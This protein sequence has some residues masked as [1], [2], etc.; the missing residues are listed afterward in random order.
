M[1]DSLSPYV[2]TPLSHGEIRLLY[3]TTDAPAD[4]TT[5]T[6]RAKRLLRADGE[7]PLMYDA[8]S[9]TWGSLGRTFPFVCNGKELQIH[10]NLKE[11]LPYLARRKSS[12]PIWIDAVC[13]N[14]T[15]DDE[16][17]VQI[18][19]M[20]KIYRQAAMAWIW[21][22]PLQ[23]GPEVITLFQELIAIGPE[24]AELRKV[25]K[26]R[27]PTDFGL[28]A[29][30]SPIWRAANDVLGN[31]WFTRVWIVQEAALPRAVK[32]LCG[33]TE[34][35]WEIIE[36]VL[37]HLV[38][39]RYALKG[40]GNARI[41]LNWTSQHTVFL[42]RH[43]EKTS[44][45]T[46]A[47]AD[48]ILSVLGLMAGNHACYDPRDY[49]LALMGFVDEERIKQLAIAESR[50]WSLAELYTRFT[51]SLLTNA[52][53]SA[54]RWWQLLH[55][56]TATNKTADL[57]SWVPSYY[58]M[59]DES[60]NAPLK[61][62][63]LLNLRRRDG[64]TYKASRASDMAEQS[65]GDYS[66]LVVR[67]KAFDMVDRTFEESPDQL[68]WRGGLSGLSAAEGVAAMRRLA[69][70]EKA[71]RSAM[72]GYGYVSVESWPEDPAY[73]QVF[74]NGTTLKLDDYWRT[75]YADCMDRGDF[76]ATYKDHC[77]ALRAF[78]RW[79]ELL[80]QAVREEEQMSLL[81]DCVPSEKPPLSDSDQAAWNLGERGGPIL[82]LI[83]SINENFFKRR[84][85]CTVGGRIGFGPARIQSGD[86]VCV[87]N[88]ADVPHTLRAHGKGRRNEYELIGET[89]VHKMMNGEVEDLDVPVVDFHLV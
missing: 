17:A 82:N 49:V 34:I 8:L 39:I 23:I 19:L 50:T 89:Y 46:L 33:V 72:L 78:H 32:F 24:L 53:Q 22:G 30:D 2:Y 41:P 75:F 12:L 60:H 67:G 76:Q 59:G 51:H 57:P 52:N 10:K 11:A 86:I 70:W 71:S 61:L 58:N 27:D 42:I 25:D 37:D 26:T 9:Y 68:A 74:V 54:F 88:N 21:F 31:K 13:I 55:E 66:R 63:S 77:A 80:E 35:S 7:P 6:L 4:R 20:H 14:Q 15:D 84:L 5:W 81:G 1:A 29:V 56:A 40:P 45:T 83:C 64:S 28:P 73:T 87:L 65:V 62:S 85:F 69:D 48:H 47:W 18:S 79:I 36:Q 38:S 16:K 3:S 44:E 43:R